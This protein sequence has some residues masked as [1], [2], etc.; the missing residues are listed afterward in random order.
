MITRFAIRS[1]IFLTATACLLLTAGCNPADNADKTASGQA[2][3][4][5]GLPQQMVQPLP[6]LQL[7]TLDERAI[8]LREYVGQP[9]VLNLWATWCPPCRR[10]MPV[11]EQAQNEFPD[12]AFVLVNQGES[13]Q[14]TLA[15]LESEGLDLTH[16]LLD[17]AS[18]TMRTLRTGG[19]PTT[20]FFD[21]QGQLVDLHLGE[22]TMADLQGMIAQHF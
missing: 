9:I 4:S 3:D 12:V 16:V 7:A 21:A 18:D 5:A 19:L 6:D 10:E 15:F 14:Q 8:S 17:Q 22:I 1:G 2:L 13:V 20:F 11:L